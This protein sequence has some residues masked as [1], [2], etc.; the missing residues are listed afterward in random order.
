MRVFTTTMICRQITDDF[1]SVYKNASNFTDTILY[2]ECM[3]I[4]SNYSDLRCIVFANDMGVPPVKSILTLLIRKGSITGDITSTDSQ[5]I[6]SL[7]GFLFKKVFL[8]Q[9][10]KDRVTVKKFGVKTAALF[11]GVEEFEIIEG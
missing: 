4:I 9:N 6:G 11:Y 5:C 3:K 2:Q 8:Y 10:Q 1:T 7:M